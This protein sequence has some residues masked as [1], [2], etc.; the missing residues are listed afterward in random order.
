MRTP[1]H[2]S[3]PSAAARPAV[4]V[5]VIT[6]NEEAQIAS[7]LES[8]IRQ[9]A[10]VEAEIIVVD[11]A[12]TDQTVS[13]AGRY[14]VTIVQLPPG[15]HLSPSAGRY[16]G[17]RASSGELLL[18][19]DGDMVLCDSWV[20]AMRDALADPAVGGVAGVLYWIRPGEPLHTDHPYR[21]PVGEHPF[22]GGAA[23]Y[24]REALEAAGSFHPFLHGEEE[25]ELG[26]RLRQK[27]YTLRRLNAP[28]AYHMAK[29]RTEGEVKEKARYFRGVGQIMRQHG[30]SA[31]TADLLLAQR[32]M[33]VSAFLLAVWLP[34]LVGL[35]VGGLTEIAAL[36]AGVSLAGILGLMA[37]KGPAR[38][39]LHARGVLLSAL[40]WIR[41][42]KMGLPD[43]GGF[44]PVL[45]A[46]TLFGAVSDSSL[47]TSP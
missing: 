40:Y 26:Y 18:F 32:R 7:T 37:L 36:L 22:L 41:G 25:R 14:P 45:T 15:D 3:S 8:V 44:E 16:A 29:P 31:L 13:I 28:M 34:L 20:E 17:T 39:V 33:F 4:S 38:V 12:S 24:R 2:T 6:R 5:I 21:S 1:A 46:A 9:T 11:S 19:V 43:P 30:F 42:L 47:H 27:G 23:A 10:K 35:L